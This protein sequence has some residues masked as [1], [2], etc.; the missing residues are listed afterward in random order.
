MFV[1]QKT[2]CGGKIV[3]NNEPTKEKGNTCGI[4]K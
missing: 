4:P 1:C 2:V 3:A